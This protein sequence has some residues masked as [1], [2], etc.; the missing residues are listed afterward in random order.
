[1][2]RDC[3]QST[4]VNIVNLSAGKVLAEE[5]IYAG[6]FLSR[7]KGFLGKKK[8]FPGKMD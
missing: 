8:L 3:H 5:A 7:L 6:T 4:R 1:M 2:V